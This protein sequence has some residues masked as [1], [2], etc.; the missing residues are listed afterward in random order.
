MSCYKFIK[1]SQTH[2]HIILDIIGAGRWLVT[3]PYTLEGR[4][5]LLE[6]TL[7]NECVSKYDKAFSKLDKSELVEEDSDASSITLNNSVITY[8]ADDF[9]LVLIADFNDNKYELKVKEMKGQKI[10]G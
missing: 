7:F 3:I 10:N 1:F 8:I 4:L 6:F 5:R 2:C 9:T